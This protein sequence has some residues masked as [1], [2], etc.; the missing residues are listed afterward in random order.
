[1]DRSW[2]IV[3]T[4]DDRGEM[5]PTQVSQGSPVVPARAMP[6]HNPWVMLV[7]AVML[8]ATAC[9]GAESRDTATSGELIKPSPAVSVAASS[10]PLDLGA[11][12][13]SSGAVLE[14]EVVAVRGP[15]WNSLDG[16]VWTLDDAPES[17]AIPW[18]YREI[19]LRVDSTLRDDLG[20]GDGI[21]TFV[22]RG[23]GDP[24]DGPDAEYGGRF[25]VGSRVVVA[26]V[27]SFQLFRDGPVDRLYPLGGPSGVFDVIGD[28]LVRQARG[29]EE[30]ELSLDGLDE[31]VT[32]SRA[33]VQSQWDGLRFPPTAA[34]Q[35]TVIEARVADLAE[36]ARAVEA[37]S[38]NPCNF[39]GDAQRAALWVA[40]NPDSSTTVD[41][42]LD[43]GFIAE[44]CDGLAVREVGR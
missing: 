12:L 11:V 36:K 35:L 41:D 39:V 28:R 42:L 20:L 25:A 1:V 13:Y 6:C 43:P 2:D 24:G 38:N 10:P 37:D 5:G 16:S 22:A 14:G 23:S 40:T 30:G 3:E 9:A 15:L 18:R 17:Y 34:Q 26:L 27:Q 32:S 4:R 44:V 8:V 33:V 29:S 19:D 31:Q 21:V 7:L